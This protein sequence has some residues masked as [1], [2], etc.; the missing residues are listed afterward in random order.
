[1]KFLQRQVT[2]MK[3]SRRLGRWDRLEVPGGGG[4]GEGGTSIVK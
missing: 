1:M 2:T 4:G 3:D